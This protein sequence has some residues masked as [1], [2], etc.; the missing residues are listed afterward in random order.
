MCLILLKNQGGLIVPSALVVEICTTAEK[1][2]YETNFPA[3]LT[4]AATLSL[5]KN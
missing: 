2:F 5:L 4:A 1:K 3:V